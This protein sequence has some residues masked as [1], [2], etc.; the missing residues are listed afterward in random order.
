MKSDYMTS[1]PSVAVLC[2]VKLEEQKCLNEFE[3]FRH[4][5]SVWNPGFGIVPF[6]G[7]HP[8]TS[9]WRIELGYELSMSSSPTTLWVVGEF[10]QIC[11]YLS[12]NDMKETVRSQISMLVNRKD[13]ESELNYGFNDIQYR[14]STS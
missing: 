4:F 8:P 10:R 2:Q 5:P 14:N 7:F 13:N 6:S 3:P 11:Y 1:Y 12:L 9:T